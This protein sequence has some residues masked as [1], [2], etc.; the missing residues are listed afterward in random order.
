MVLDKAG[1]FVVPGGVFGKQGARNI[2]IS[3]CVPAE[4]LAKATAKIIEAKI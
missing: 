3:L 2:R 1:V 4:T